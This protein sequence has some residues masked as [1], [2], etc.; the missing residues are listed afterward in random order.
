LAEP[1]GVILQVERKTLQLLKR[2]VVLGIDAE[3]NAGLALGSA[4]AVILPSKVQV[5]AID[6]GDLEGSLKRQAFVQS[7]ANICDMER[8]KI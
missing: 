8:I 6:Y 3:L 4:K 7:A 1:L 5:A 2:D